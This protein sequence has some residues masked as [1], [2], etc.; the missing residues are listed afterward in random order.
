V[1]PDITGAVAAPRG[2]NWRDSW[3]LPGTRHAFGSDAIHSAV[4][5]SSV[6]KVLPAPRWAGVAAN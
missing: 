2:E 1:G 3:P 5:T 4:V 6:A